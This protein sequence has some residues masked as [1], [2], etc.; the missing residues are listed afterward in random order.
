VLTRDRTSGRLLGRLYELV[1]GRHQ[2][3]A[4][5][6]HDSHL[7]NLAAIGLRLD[8]AAVRL[9]RGE[10]GLVRQLLGRLG[11]QVREELAALR[12][13]VAAL[14][15]LVLDRRG[16]AAAVQEL[17]AATVMFRVAQQALA[18]V[19]QHANA[20]RLRVALYRDGPQVVLAVEDDG[21]GFDPL[22]TDTVTDAHGFGL[23]CMRERLQAIGGQ[24]TLRTAPGA[25]TCIEAPAASHAPP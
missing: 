10:A 17:A 24:L 6:L 5:D 23:S 20:R 4:A 19:E 8:H 21:C 18:N 15:P 11:Q 1:E 12:R 2:R 22:H 7:Q 13:T 14:R 9:E 16:L 25:G 3:L